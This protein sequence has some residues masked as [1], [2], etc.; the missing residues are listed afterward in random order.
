MAQRWLARGDQVTALTRSAE[1][2]GR[3]IEAGM[4]VH[5]GDVT[6]ASSLQTLPIADVVLYAVSY[7]RHS[8]SKRED[9]VVSGLAGA[10]EVLADKTR[11]LIYISTS[12]VYGVSNGGW[13]DETT[14][15]EPANESGRLALEAEGLVRASPLEAI[16]LR[17]T[18]I[19]G[20]G[21][22][23]RRIEQMA[24]REPI[25]GEGD[26]WLNLIHVD[27][28]ARAVELAADRLLGRLD[29]AAQPDRTFLVSDDEPIRRRDYYARLA[30]AARA[31]A[32]VFDPGAGGSR[33]IGVGKRCRN[34]RVK[35]ELG[36]TLEHPRVTEEQ[37]K[38][39][40]AI[41]S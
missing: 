32:P 36:L 24:A 23:L 34:D 11:R 18:G 19:Y 37:F 28:A 29:A 14:P 1:R 38:K 26:A 6:D 27:D 3:L 12:S 7:D 31:P 25:A 20:P 30:R 13:V 8:A 15:T 39:M 10:L 22:L 5:V 40:L 16:Q 2:A 4:G 21:R 17:M 9:V 33:I 41:G 35:E